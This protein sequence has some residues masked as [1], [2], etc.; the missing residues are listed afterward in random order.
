MDPDEFTIDIPLVL[1]MEPDKREECCIYKV[2]KLISIGPFHHGNE[3]LKN[4]EDFKVRYLKEAC[5]RTKKKPVELAKCIL[6]NEV[7]IH[8]CYAEILDMSTDEFVKMILFDSIFIIEHLW[9]TKQNPPMSPPIVSNSRTSSSFYRCQCRILDSCLMTCQRGSEED[10]RENRNPKPGNDEKESPWQSYNILQDLR[11]LENQVPF[12][13]LKEL[14]NFAYRDLCYC[15]QNPDHNEDEG[16]SFH[17]KK[18]HF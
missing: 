3:D 1:N 15:C 18:N 8:H 17:Y 12:F 16:N 9:K 7:K 2:L 5:Y 4:M 14:Y 13:I 10:S 6:E 11:L